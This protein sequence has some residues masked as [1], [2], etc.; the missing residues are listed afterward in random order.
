MLDIILTNK[1]NLYCVPIIAPP[2]PPDDPLCGVPSDHST[3][4]A[5]PLATDTLQ[6]AR[7]YVVKVTR[8]LPESGM[9]EFGEWICSEEWAEIS[10]GCDPTEQV[11]IFEQIINQKLEVI[12]PTKT[13]RINPNIDLPFITADLKNYNTGCIR[14]W[15]ASS[16]RFGNQNYLGTPDGYTEL[17]REVAPPPKNGG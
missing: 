11:V 12:F 17:S 6:Q 5:T 9:L 4:V 2:V 7:E 13:V 10:E 16:G 15:S 8:P 14:W 1:A 3:P